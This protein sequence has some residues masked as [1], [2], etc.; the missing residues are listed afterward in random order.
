MPAATRLARKARFEL[1]S[2]PSLHAPCARTR[3]TKSNPPQR[4][5]PVG[6]VLHCTMHSWRRS[7][8]TARPKAALLTL[9]ALAGVV[10]LLLARRPP[11]R[12]AVVTRELV[13]IPITLVPLS[14]PPPVEEEQVVEA[15]GEPTATAPV[16]ETLR[17]PRPTSAITLPTVEEAADAPPSQPDPDDIDWHA[18]AALSAARVAEELESP[19]TFGK[20][21]EK[22]R[23]P[24]K[25]P[26]SSFRF[27][28]SGTSTGG[29]ARLTL[30]WEP[31]PPDK[32]LF[33]DMLAGRTPRSSVPDPNVCD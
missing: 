11:T 30:G 14:P 24:C 31:N 1:C 18:Q 28:G 33:D 6:G 12:P 23:E 3:L 32:H 22:M 26:R 15:G 8:W 10:R 27:K 19:A 7:I 9:A 21:L 25:P 13:N 17:V 16:R 2:I 29:S 5:L 20:P 4:R